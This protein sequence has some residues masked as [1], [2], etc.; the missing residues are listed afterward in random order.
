MIF[1]KNTTE[2]INNLANKLTESIKNGIILCSYMEHHSNLLPWRKNFN[3]EYIN[4]DKKGRLCLDDYEEKLRSYHGR[5]KLVAV[6]GASNVTGYKTDIHLLARLAHKYGAKIVAFS[7]GNYTLPDL[8]D[9]KDIYDI[10]FPGT[11]ANKG[12]PICTVQTF[13]KDRKEV[14]NKALQIIKEIYNKCEK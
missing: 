13:G 3:I 7:A 12:S 5:I 11:V 9:L 6:S 14:M 4:I 1:V 10:P 2:A 8:A